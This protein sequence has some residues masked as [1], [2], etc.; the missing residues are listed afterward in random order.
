MKHSLLQAVFVLHLV[1]LCSS[2]LS[3]HYYVMPVHSTESAYHG[4]QNGT[5][6]TLNQLAQSN[7]TSA[8][9][10]NL[11]LS[12]LPGEHVLTQSLAIHSFTH[13]QMRGMNESVVYFHGNGQIEISNSDKLKIEYLDFVQ[14]QTIEPVRNYIS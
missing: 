12:F 1:A 11:T 13:V 9:E 7:L 6:L 4:Y 3:N 14:N 10:T 5:C 2:A 8:G